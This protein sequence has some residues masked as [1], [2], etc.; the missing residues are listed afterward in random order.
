MKA[1]FE[2]AIKVLRNGFILSGLYFFSIYAVTDV[3]TYTACKPV[4]VFL[5]TYFFTEMIA[6][7]GLGKVNNKRLNVQTLVL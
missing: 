7:Y 6:R 4:L 5:G 2:H 3:L 1:D